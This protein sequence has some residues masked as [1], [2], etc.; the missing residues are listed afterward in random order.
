MRQAIA[1]SKPMPSSKPPHSLRRTLTTFIATGDLFI[2]PIKAGIDLSR[3][4]LAR[5]ARPAPLLARFAQAGFAVAR[6]AV[7][8]VGNPYA[9]PLRV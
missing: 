9:D 2:D 5:F 6:S 7:A 3:F 1:V 8:N 4:A